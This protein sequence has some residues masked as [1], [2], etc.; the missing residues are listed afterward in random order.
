MSFVLSE[1]LYYTKN[2]EW[3][4]VD[5]NL[6]TI[7]LTEY[8]IQSLGEVLYLDLP[9]D[10]QKMSPGQNIGSLESIKGIHDLFA[11]VNGTV[12]EVNTSLIEDPTLINDDTLGEGWLIRLE[13][14]SEKDLAGLL[15]SKEYRDFLGTLS[16]K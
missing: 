8:A 2:H 14:D 5:E 3:L 11:S 1:E 15:R 10:S 9:E 16:A 6:V 4:H 13:M 7:G 12:L